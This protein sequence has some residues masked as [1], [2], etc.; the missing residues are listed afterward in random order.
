[1]EPLEIK[2]GQGIDPDPYASE[3]LVLLEP[4]TSASTN[5]A[6]SAIVHPFQCNAFGG[7]EVQPEHTF[8]LEPG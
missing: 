5:S 1:M 2:E 4:E 6:T 8:L 3:T 7:V